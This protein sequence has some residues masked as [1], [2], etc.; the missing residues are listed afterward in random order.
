MNPECEIKDIS[1]TFSNGSTNDYDHGYFNGTIYGYLNST[2]QAYAEKYS[3]AFESLGDAPIQ[4]TTAVTTAP[5]VTTTTTTATTPSS[6]EIDLSKVKYCDINLDNEVAIADIAVLS[7]YVTAS[8]LY[9]LKN[10]TAVEN[11]DV[12]HDSS[13]TSADVQKL[14]E[15]ILK[16]ITSL[17]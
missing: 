17:D 9:S 13:I 12:N 6:D 3:Y 4:T 2:A 15:F 10:A 5:V 14:I 16:T 1:S 7:K 11:S 8:E